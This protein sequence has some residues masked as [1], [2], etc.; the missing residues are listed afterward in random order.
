MRLTILFNDAVKMTL[1]HM[2]ESEKSEE[3]CKE[4]HDM[5][6]GSRKIRLVGITLAS[7]SRMVVKESFVGILSSYAGIFRSPCRRAFLKKPSR[8]RIARLQ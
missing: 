1:K 6:L 5:P 2:R 8:E 7:G 3:V 4:G